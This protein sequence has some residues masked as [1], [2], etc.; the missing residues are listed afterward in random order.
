VPQIGTFHQR[1]EDVFYKSDPTGNLE[2]NGALP[3]EVEF[4]CPSGQEGN[5]TGSRV[6][7]NAFTSGARLLGWI[8]GKLQSMGVR[9]VVPG[10]DVLAEA[11]RLAYRDRLVRRG[12][13][14]LRAEAEEAA[15]AVPLPPDLSGWVGRKLEGAPALPWDEAL[16]GRAARDIQQ[17]ESP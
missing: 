3:E 13:V 1:G 4:L 7:L 6:E 11:Y 2:D 16:A 10:D 17:A 5:Y 15:L 9:K 14:K 8:E 12:M